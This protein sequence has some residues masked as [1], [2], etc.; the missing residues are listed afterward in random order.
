MESTQIENPSHLNTELVCGLTAATRTP[1]P[2]PTGREEAALAEAISHQEGFWRLPGVAL[3]WWDLDC[4]PTSSLQSRQVKGNLALSIS[5]LAGSRWILTL[6]PK[7]QDASVKDPS[8]CRNF[9]PY[10][11]SICPFSQ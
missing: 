6:K 9:R 8:S 10:K 11:A 1:K 5:F 2:V 3:D 4:R 7:L